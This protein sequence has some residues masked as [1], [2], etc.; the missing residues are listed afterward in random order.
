MGVVQKNTTYYR[1]GEL[2][3]LTGKQ[4]KSYLKFYEIEVA[5]IAMSKSYL[6]NIN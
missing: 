2:D 5:K 4:I 1:P 6:S 3:K